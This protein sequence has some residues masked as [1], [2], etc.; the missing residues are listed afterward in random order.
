MI[1]I[2]VLIR[3]AVAT[4]SL[5]TPLVLI[6]RV[7]L[8][9]GWGTRLAALWEVEE[10]VKTGTV[11]GVVGSATMQ[12]TYVGGGVGYHLLEPTSTEAFHIIKTCFGDGAP[13]G[14]RGARGDGSQFNILTL[15]RICLDWVLVVALSGWEQGF[16]F[17]V[18]NI[19]ELREV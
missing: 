5:V 17:L 3:S 16:V 13:V 11:L 12:D 2:S 4:G 19:Y 14:T 8:I 1:A 15:G 10:V 18:D 7:G 9:V 6:V